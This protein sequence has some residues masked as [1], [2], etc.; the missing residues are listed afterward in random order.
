MQ[1][2]V[3]CG[4][5]VVCDDVAVSVKRKSLNSLGLCRLGHEYFSSVF[6]TTRLSIP[7]HKTSQGKQKPI[8]FEDAIRKTVEILNESKKPLLL[9][10]SNSTFEA[11]KIGLML[12][13]RT[14]GVF[15]STASYEYGNLFDAKLKG[16][17]A[18]LM[19]LDEVRN[20][21][22][23]IVY[24]GIN[25]AESHHRHASRYTV[26]PKGEQIP[27][28]RESRV[29]SVIDIRESESMR[30]A[31]HQLI[32]APNTGDLQFLQLLIAEL[33]GTREHLP[34]KVGG[35]PAIEFL[36]F[37]KQL[38]EA[39]KI[40]LFYGNGLIH[41]NHSSK[42]LPLLQR[43]HKLL[44]RGKQKCWILP[45]VEYCNSIGAVRASLDATNLPFSVDFS[46]KTPKFLN[47]IEQRI[48]KGYFDCA[49]ISGW[50]ALSLL[51]GPIAKTLSELPSIALSS[52]PTLTTLWAQIALPIAL[53]GAETSGTVF[54]MDGTAV[55]LQPFIQAPKGIPM[56]EELLKQLLTLIE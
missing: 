53:T 37:A 2:T 47:S 50:D 31:N 1:D 34:E 43:V 46:S 9:G 16:G 55:P 42:S 45:M 24:W 7:V 4:C 36:S 22:D 54:R 10:W 32:L 8:S 26:F 13:Q 41:S 27:E 20:A 6:S 35:V 3:C 15:D 44:N 33:D 56:E 40:A 14:Q 48:K 30:L 19:N 51:P 28:G 11:I 52:H 25:P 23:H 29:V 5:S 17:E 39:E 49:V 18:Q 38:R 12:A 21:A